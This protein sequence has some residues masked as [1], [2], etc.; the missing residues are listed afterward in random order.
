[1]FLNFF[2]STL[3]IF[4]SFSFFIQTIVNTKNCYA[5]SMFA[6]EQYHLR[7]VCVQYISQFRIFYMN[8]NE[9]RWYYP[10]INPKYVNKALIQLNNYSKFTIPFYNHIFNYILVYR[11]NGIQ[12][13]IQSMHQAD[14][15]G[16]WQQ[17]TVFVRGVL[18]CTLFHYI[19]DTCPIYVSNLVFYGENAGRPKARSM[20]VIPYTRGSSTLCS[21]IISFPLLNPLAQNM[22][23]YKK[24]HCRSWGTWHL[25]TFDSNSQECGSHL[26]ENEQ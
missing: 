12:E 2:P 6:Q 19:L 20:M 23:P 8:M 16:L 9:K 3:N 24:Q 4:Y 26:R 22:K 10:R 18:F 7:K 17:I 11:L 15:I 25:E 21:L 1:M 5:V 14:F 13:D